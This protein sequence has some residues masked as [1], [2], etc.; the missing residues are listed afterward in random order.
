MRA[1]AQ[2]ANRRIDGADRSHSFSSS[3]CQRKRVDQ[4]L[5]ERRRA[6]RPVPRQPPSRWRWAK[7]FWARSPSARP[8]APYT[9]RATART[10]RAAAA[11]SDDPARLRVR[12][13]PW[14][15]AET[16]GSSDTRPLGVM[17][18]RVEVR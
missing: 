18:T 16:L 13:A 12:V 9:V 6:A 8:F 3:E 15:P 2:S 14:V 1:N 10:G 7:T 5:D 4:S 11:A 17:V